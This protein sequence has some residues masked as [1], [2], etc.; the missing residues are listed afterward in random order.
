MKTLEFKDRQVRYSVEGSG[1]PVFLIHGYLESLEVWN[2]LAADLAADHQ[3]IRMDLPGHG[4]SEVIQDTHRMELL[5][6]AA[7]EVLDREGIE[8]CSMFGHS[9]GGYATLAFLDL[10]PGRLKGFSLFHSHPFA[11]SDQVRQKRQGEIDLVNQGQKEEILKVNVPKL[12]ATD[13]L[14]A[15]SREVE[16]VR[17][18]AEATPGEGIIANLRGM[19]QRPD[20][21]GLVKETDKPF[22]LIAGRKDNYIPYDAVIPQI[23]L[24]EKGRLVTL[25]HSGHLGFVE[26]K[27]RSLETIRAFTGSLA[28]RG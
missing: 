28:G 1:E 21:S 18:M 4:K 5:A 25:K 3:V 7:R 9:L 12:F 24:P 10:Y 15:F 27:A 14:Q 17:E 8:R 20:R 19:M 26:E 16:W 23:E 22:L 13:N 6:E 2:G 11:D